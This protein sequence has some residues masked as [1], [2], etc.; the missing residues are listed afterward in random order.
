MSKYRIIATQTPLGPLR[1]SFRVEI[2]RRWW[3]FWCDITPF[4]G[5]SDKDDAREYALAYG[6][7]F[8]VEEIEA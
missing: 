8:V 2:K 4:G 3:P 7:S 1:L 6:K 5:L